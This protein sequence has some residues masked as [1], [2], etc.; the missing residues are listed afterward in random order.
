MATMRVRL[1]KASAEGQKKLDI[2]E[3]LVSD[4][5]D[6]IEHDTARHFHTPIPIS[7]QEIQRIWKNY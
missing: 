6:W 7:I 4:L 2:S 1:K 5:Q 3:K